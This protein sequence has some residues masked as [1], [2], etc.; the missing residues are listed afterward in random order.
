MKPSSMLRI[1]THIRR[2][3]KHV[4][5]KAAWNPGFVHPCIY[6]LHSCAVGHTDYEFQ[7]LSAYIFADCDTCRCELAS[8]CSVAVL[9]EL[10]VV[11][12]KDQHLFSLA[13]KFKLYF[14]FEFN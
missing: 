12:R 11:C 7:L 8:L 9:P 13:I 1:H 2:H 5:V 14:E 6:V 4:V 10:L 3:L